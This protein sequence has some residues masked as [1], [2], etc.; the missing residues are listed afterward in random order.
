MALEKCY[1][2]Y[3]Q[4]TAFFII[5]L[6][7]QRDPSGYWLHVSDADDLHARAMRAHN[8]PLSKGL[9][10]PRLLDNAQGVG[11]YLYRAD[12]ARLCVV[13]INGRI[14]YDSPDTHDG[15]RKDLDQVM[16][17]TLDQLAAHG[18]AVT[19]EWDARAQSGAAGKPAVSF[20]LPR[21]EY[22]SAPKTGK[23]SLVE[24]ND[25]RGQKAQVPADVRDDFL[26][27]RALVAH[28]FTGAVPP[29]ATRPVVLIF[30]NERSLPAGSATAAVEAFFRA[31]QGR[32][33]C[34]LVYTQDKPGTWFAN[35]A[36][37]ATR[38]LR[39]GK[40]T[41]PCLLDSPE[42]EV[43][44]AYATASARL[45]L[46]APDAKQHWVVRYASRPGAAGVAV[47]LKES[48]RFLR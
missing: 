13:D 21:V 38:W 46:V 29:A 4:H 23:G 36:Q 30:G 15:E 47:G 9:T 42:G 32:A 41:L 16:A 28:L 11:D 1:Q 27:K 39:A 40:L 14:A 5:Y 37:A 31:Q 33:D 7:E 45:I 34:Y 43:G 18:G 6:A 26:H 3:R 48:A 10:M 17:R 24:V 8:C 35:A 22:F 25:A 20:W 44:H 12:P 2:K 19:A